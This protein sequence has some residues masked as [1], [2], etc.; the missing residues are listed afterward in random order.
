[1]GWVT[2]SIHRIPRRLDPLRCFARHPNLL[3]STRFGAGHS[4]ASCTNNFD[5]RVTEE[6]A[7]RADIR[8]P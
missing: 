7:N 4:A 2:G 6:F 8:T 1:M 5:R 3:D